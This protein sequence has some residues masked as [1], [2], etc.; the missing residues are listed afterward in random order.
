[1][2]F[3]VLTMKEGPDRREGIMY[4]YQQ[5]FISQT[6]LLKGMQR[7]PFPTYNELKITSFCR[8]LYATSRF[9]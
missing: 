9:Y 2:G 6:E 5:Y 3:C 8:E 7:L 4:I 1:M